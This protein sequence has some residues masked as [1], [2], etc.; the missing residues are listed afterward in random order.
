MKKFIEA[1][2]CTIIVNIAIILIT[3]DINITSVTIITFMLLG[4]YFY[5]EQDNLLYKRVFTLALFIIGSIGI[6]Y[7]HGIGEDLLVFYVV[8]IIYILLLGRDIFKKTK[9]LISK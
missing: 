5:R 2:I 9:N 4:R 6:I 3:S 8:I 1:L 7:Y